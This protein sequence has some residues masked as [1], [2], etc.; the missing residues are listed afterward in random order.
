MS[1]QPNF[2]GEFWLADSAGTLTEIDGVLSAAFPNPTRGTYRTSNHKTTGGH[3]YKA[4]ALPEP[5]TFTVR[6]QY[7]SG[8][9]TDLLLLDAYTDKEPRAYRRVFPGGSG[10]RMLDGE[11]ILTNYQV[12]DQALEGQQEA[13]LT[14]QGSGGVT[15]ADA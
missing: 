12:Q 4:E 13:I 10:N 3:T 5:G 15:P 6:I 11:A 9:A 8:S 7:D 1:S 14:F 2:G